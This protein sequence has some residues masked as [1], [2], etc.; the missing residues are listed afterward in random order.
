MFR[1]ILRKLRRSPAFTLTSIVVLAIGIGATSAIFSVV[2]G[3]SIQPPPYAQPE[4]LIALTHRAENTSQARL[5]A[6]TAICFTYRDTTA[7][8]IP[9]RCGRSIPRRS[10]APAHPRKSESRNQFEFLPMPGVK[11]ESGRFFA[12]SDDQPGSPRTVI[13]SHGYWQRRFGGAD[14]VGRSMAVDAVPHEV[15]G[16]L[17]QSFR[18]LQQ[19]ADVLLPLQPNRAI[20]FV[21]PLGKM[22]FARL[23]P[24][25]TLESASA[26]IERMIP[27]LTSTFPP[28]P[29]MDM[30]ASQN[31]RL[32][33]DLRYL[34]EAIVGD[35]RNV[36]S[37]LIG[38]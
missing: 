34:K 15:I 31:L 22:A 11:P 37:V 17:P 30:R 36:L 9:S 8:S 25:V 28:V 7:L 38:P 10:P 14:V 23:R 16:V 24:G 2:Y 26:D 18:V 32:H 12:S 19:D 27:I 20:S 4:R 5:P 35:L 33:P 6:S 1:Q 3:V 13:L 21:G 29:G